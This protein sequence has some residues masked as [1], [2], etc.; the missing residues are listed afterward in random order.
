[1]QVRSEGEVCRHTV[2]EATHLLK[3]Q[4]LPEHFFMDVV[5]THAHERERLSDRNVVVSALKRCCG[6]RCA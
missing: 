1:M 2:S 6:D 4:L 5:E 3:R